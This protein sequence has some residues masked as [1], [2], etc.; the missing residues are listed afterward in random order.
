MDSNKPIIRIS[1]RNLVEFILRSGDIDSGF[2]GPNR[3]AEG[4]RI[5]RN[6][7]KSRKGNYKSEV[8]V[9]KTSISV[10][11]L[12]WLSRE[13]SMEFWKPMGSFV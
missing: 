8:S 6:L 10:M 9:N 4:T 2:C 1:V 13:E 5:H 12:L 7:Q 11:I 3:A